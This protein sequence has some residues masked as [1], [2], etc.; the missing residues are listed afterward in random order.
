MI[1][2]RME[3]SNLDGGDG[4]GNGAGMGTEEV[5]AWLEGVHVELSPEIGETGKIPVE[6]G[7]QE[8][9]GEGV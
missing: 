8:L 5:G 9:D 3:V 1:F 4:G 6:V 2:E 7:D